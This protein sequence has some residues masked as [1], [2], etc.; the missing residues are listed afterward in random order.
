[1]ISARALG[2]LVAAM[3]FLTTQLEYA[4]VAAV[5]LPFFATLLA[6]HIDRDSGRMSR[7]LVGVAASL[8]PSRYRA[9]SREEW[10]DHVLSA[11]EHG[12][13][14]LTRALSIVFIAAPM[15]AVGLRVGRSTEKA[16]R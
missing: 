12:V 9:Q 5:L 16:K 1:M 13:L 15:L 7:A 2:I 10:L 4:L 14:P 3:G 6:S 11:G 8:L